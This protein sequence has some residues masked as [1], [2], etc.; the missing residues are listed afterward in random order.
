MHLF[1]K[2]RYYRN[3]FHNLYYF[4]PSSSFLSLKNHI[5]EKHDKIYHELTVSDL[6]EWGRIEDADLV[7]AAFY[8]VASGL[9][10]GR[11]IGGLLLRWRP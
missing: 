8:R 5:F 10:I 4:C 2:K 7:I 11:I 3:K 6:N 1:S 9:K